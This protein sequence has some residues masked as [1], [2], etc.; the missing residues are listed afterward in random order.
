MARHLVNACDN[1]GRHWEL[2]PAQAVEEATCVEVEKVIAA[3][4]ISSQAAGNGANSTRT[5]GVVMVLMYLGIGTKLNVAVFIE[6]DVVSSDNVAR[7]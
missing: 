1:V 2:C 3:M 5:H 6:I 4:Y 7:T